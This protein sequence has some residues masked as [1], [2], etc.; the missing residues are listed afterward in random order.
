MDKNI[1]FSIF[2][3][4]KPGVLSQIFRELARA[5]VN[6]TSLAMMDSTEHGVLRLVVDD[7]PTTRT[8]L[9]RLNIPVTEAEVLTVELTN[10]PGAAADL[11]DK[12]SAAHMNIGYLYCTSGAK[13][14]RSVVVFKVPD[15]NKAMKVIENSNKTPRRDIKIKLRRPTTAKR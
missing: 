9:A 12:L 10:R 3:V 5:K 7:P 14:G 6:I 2:L 4:N 13:S 11:C 1:Q 8:V 15:L